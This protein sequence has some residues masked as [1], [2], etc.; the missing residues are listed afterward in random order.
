M[1]TI[2][3]EV[4]ITSTSCPEDGGSSYLRNIGN[5]SQKAVIIIIIIIIIISG[6]PALSEP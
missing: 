3:P 5:T 2:V 6:K 4:T 1:F